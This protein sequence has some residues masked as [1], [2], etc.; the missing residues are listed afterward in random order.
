MTKFISIPEHYAVYCRERGFIQ[1]S[2][3]PEEEANEDVEEEA[4]EDVEEDFMDDEVEEDEA[5]ALLES[6]SVDKEGDL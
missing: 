4:N 5:D 2:T 1:A 6:N 3:K